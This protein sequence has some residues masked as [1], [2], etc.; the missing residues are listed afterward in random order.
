MKNTLDLP[1]YRRNSRA[2]LFVSEHGKCVSSEN[3]HFFRTSRWEMVIMLIKFK[4]SWFDS[5]SNHCRNS[6]YIPIYHFSF[7]KISQT[8]NTL[9]NMRHFAKSENWSYLQKKN[10]KLPYNKVNAVLCVFYIK[11]GECLSYDTNVNWKL[12]NLS[13]NR[14]IILYYSLAEIIWSDISSYR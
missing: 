13:R 1:D 4:T 11:S 8:T 10:N 5:L 14:F 9:K 12:W 3:R 7:S 2:D 6:E